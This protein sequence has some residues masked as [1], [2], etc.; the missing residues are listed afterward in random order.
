MFTFSSMIPYLFYE[1]MHPSIF[2]KIVVQSKK[3]LF[4]N[5]YPGPP[6]VDPTP[7]EQVI[8][9]EQLEKRIF[10]LV[11]CPFYHTV[12]LFHCVLTPKIAAMAPI[13]FG[14]NLKVQ[15]QT[16]K[17]ILD[18]L[19]SSKCNVH[20][21]LFIF[22]AIL[23]TIF[24]ELALSAARDGSEPSQEDNGSASSTPHILSNGPDDRPLSGMS[25]L[26]TSEL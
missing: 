6:P 18:P 21:L 12:W 10:N 9:R 2:T 7:E 5:G 22:D 14:P 25:L 4:P 8:L 19:N 16:V 1:Q 13:M 23:V 15:Q 3:V 17:G 26:S 20:L 24:P 11:P